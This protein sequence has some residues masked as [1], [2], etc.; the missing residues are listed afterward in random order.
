MEHTGRARSPSV[1]DGRSPAQA[2]R[3]TSKTALKTMLGTVAPRWTAS[4]MAA[5][6]RAH[7][8]R[9]VREWGLDVVTRKLVDHFGNRVL[10]GPCAGLA[11]SP[12]CQ[13]E[14][15]GPFLLGVYESELDPAWAVV[16]E[17]GYD[18][19]VDVGAKF[20]YYACALA[21]RYPDAEVV[22][23]D[24]DPW[25][26]RAM[27][28]MAD[29]NE[30]GNVRVKGFCDPDWFNDNLRQSAFIISDCE[31]Y[32]GALFGDV[33]PGALRSA[34]LI[35][36]THDCFVPGVAARVRAIFKSTHDIHTID[37]RLPRRLSTHRLDFLSAEEQHSAQ[38]EVR[39]EQEWLLCLPRTGRNQEL[40]NR[41]EA[42]R[43]IQ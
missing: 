41:A 18:Q 24:I 34:T 42:L 27:R 32:E 17:G 33:T 6:A 13:A 9:L 5:R 31:G 38:H 37:G 10:E 26:Q 20:G 16:L 22:A 40:R 29:V 28:E 36:E 19:V 21:R 4:L 39:G 14:H 3:M 12:I 7:S 1:D 25:A 43:G 2:G 8:Q 30:T 35:V 15:L 11:L 23:F